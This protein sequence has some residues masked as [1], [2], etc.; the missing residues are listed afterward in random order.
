MRF[1][2][3]RHNADDI[4]FEGDWQG[5][6]TEALNHGYTPSQTVGIVRLNGFHGPMKDNGVIRYEDATTYNT[7][8][9]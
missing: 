2:I 5:F 7:L 1:R 6:L 4:L 8:S 3:V 9:A